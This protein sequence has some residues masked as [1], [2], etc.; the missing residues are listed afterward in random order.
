MYHSSVDITIKKQ[1]GWVVH[2]C[3]ELEFPTKNTSVVLSPSSWS[4]IG[5]WNV[6]LKMYAKLQNYVHMVFKNLVFREMNR[7]LHCTVKC[8][9]GWKLPPILSNNLNNQELVLL[10]YIGAMVWTHFWRR[11]FTFM[12][13]FFSE[14]NLS[15]IN[16]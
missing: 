6:F 4:E 7:N 12:F 5:I 16:C 11:I 3:L 1:S 9:C 14:Y 15:I 8:I 13:L 2:F 10:Q